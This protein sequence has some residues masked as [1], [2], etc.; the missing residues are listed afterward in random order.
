MLFNNATR[1]AL[2]VG[3]LAVAGNEIRLMLHDFG[4][5]L[6][7][8][9]FFGSLAV[10]AAAILFGRR[11]EVPQIALTVP[12]II[13]MVPGIAAFQTIV[14]LNRGQM[15]EALQAAAVCGFAIGAMAMG[16]AAARV[17]DRARSRIRP[18]PS[19]A[20][21]ADKRTSRRRRP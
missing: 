18:A 8:A 17:F 19:A 7:P 15:L 1:P 5:M 13:I 9:A 2:G 11:L 16:L 14:L 12:G 6:A 3:I 21:C 10:G 20:L 4:M